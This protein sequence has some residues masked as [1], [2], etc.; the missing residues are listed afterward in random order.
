M[1]R[2]NTRPMRPGAAQTLDLRAAIHNRFDVEVLDAATGELKRRAR[3]F[4]VI[5]DG[6]W[7][8]LLHTN[9][10]NNWSPQDY[11]NYILFGS[12]SGTPA[13]TDTTL[14]TKVGAIATADNSI[15]HTFSYRTGVFSN[16]AVVTL[17]AEDYVGVTLTEVGIGY[18]DTHVATHAM[19]QDMNGNPISIEKTATD[20]IKIYATVFVHWPD[21]G[22]YGGSVNVA[23]MN[24]DPNMLY[25]FAGSWSWNNNNTSFSLFDVDKKT[26]ARSALRELT[27]AVDAANKTLSFTTRLAAAEY[28]MPIRS[29]L[30]GTHRYAATHTYSDA[31]RVLLGSWF[32]P[33]AISGEA[34]GTGD[35]SSVGFNTAFPVKTAGTVYVDGVAAADAAVRLGPSDGNHAEQYF[36]QL[37]AATASAGALS[38]SGAPLYAA[39]TTVTTAGAIVINLTAGGDPSAAFENP[40]AAVGIGSFSVWCQ[41]ARRLTVEASDDCETWTQAVEILSGAGSYNTDAVPAAL[42]NKKYWRFKNTSTTT[43]T[44]TFSITAAVPAA[45]PVHNIVFSAAPA[46][47]AVITCDY[48]PDCIAKD[49]NHVFDITVT[50]T[51]GEYQ[52]V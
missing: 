19:L 52:E 24:G 42:Q 10:S 38:Q 17:Q 40:F 37:A 47:G 46:A 22:W 35:G 50:L 25:I 21:G 34:V 49:E 7:S 30:F 29:I 48:T 4:N 32:T 8:R 18:D 26:A 36:N 13:S 3:G 27:T 5:C 14:F 43:G 16:Q 2:G 31:I 45:D 1:L 23:R 44:N 6:L 20:V 12:G 9:S 15:V 51:L 33:P 41:Y 11:M 28:N 39:E